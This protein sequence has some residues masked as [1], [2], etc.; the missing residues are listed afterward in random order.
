MKEVFAENFGEEPL[1]VQIRLS[2]FMVMDGTTI[3]GGVQNDVGTW[4]NW[5]P[6]LSPVDPFGP[7]TAIAGV[8]ATAAPLANNS[9]WTWNMGGQTTFMPTFN[10]VP[11]CR[12]SDIRG[13]VYWADTA[14]TT[15]QEN[16]VQQAPH[17]I[18]GGSGAPL[19]NPLPPAGGWVAVYDQNGNPIDPP[20]TLVP[21]STH[22]E[23]TLYTRNPNNPNQ[24]VNELE[25]HYAQLTHPA[26]IVLR[27][28]WDTWDSTTRLGFVGWIIDPDGLAT[29]SRLLPPGQ[30]TGMLLNGIAFNGTTT[31]EWFYAINAHG[32][33]FTEASAPDHPVVE[34]ILNPDVDLEVLVDGVVESEIELEVGDEV[35]IELEFNVTVGNEDV[36]ITMLV[37]DIVELTPTNS[38]NMEALD[39]GVTVITFTSDYNNAIVATLTVTVV[40]DSETLATV[41]GAT[42][43]TAAHPTHTLAGAFSLATGERGDPATT[44][45]DGRIPLSTILVD[46][47]TTGLSVVYADNQVR[48]DRGHF[49]IDTVG[50]YLV[51]AGYWPVYEDWYANDYDFAGP[52]AVN[53]RLIRDGRSVD[54][55]IYADF[56]DSL[57]S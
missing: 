3:I 52:F 13:N 16:M 11:E 29:W 49:S 15:D 50:G 34:W 48:F 40:D 30:A 22:I 42:E 1:I 43:F 38:W 47:N 54:I 31:D 35:L 25:T 6:G 51:F 12:Q 41:G 20:V 39:T 23:D 21:G 56:T 9:W 28:Q 2:E 33:F 10:H 37:D 36:T 8:D 27:S 4:R 18:P 55:T 46:P 32:F 57:A 44:D 17:G 5:T 19:V 26:G 7:T 24:I 45:R 53:V 14:G